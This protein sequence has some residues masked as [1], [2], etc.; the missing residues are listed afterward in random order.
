MKRAILFIIL[1]VALIIAFSSPLRAQSSNNRNQKD[2]LRQEILLAD[3]DSKLRLYNGLASL[4]MSEVSRDEHIIDTI[5]ALYDEM[6]A[7]A[8]KSGNLTYQGYARLNKL[9]ALSNKGA[10]DEIIQGVPAALDFLKEHSQWNSYYQALALLCDTYG[11]KGETET[12]LREAQLLYEDA[13]ARKHIGGT[14]VALRSISKIYKGKRRF[15][16]AEKCLRECIELL[17]DSISYYSVLLD[18][19]SDLISNLIAQKRYEDA[20]QM[21]SEYEKINLYYEKESKSS[22]PGVWSNLWNQYIYIYLQSGD[23]DRAEIYINKLDSISN[24]SR[25]LSEERAQV[26]YGKKQYDEA[27]EIIN[28]KI[29]LSPNSLQSKGL[30]LMILIQMGKADEGY[31]LFRNVIS[32]LDSLRNTEFNAR[33]DEIHTQYQVDKH[34]AEKE[35]N[36]N[37]FFFALGGCCVFIALLA[38]AFYYNRIITKKN[39][40]L[41]KQINEQRRIYEDV[42]QM[43]LQI[44]VE[45]LSRELKLYLKLQRLMQTE[46][47]F[48]DPDFDRGKLIERLGTN[49]QYLAD[50]LKQ[51]AGLTFGAY[52]TDLRLKYALEL[53]SDHPNLTLDAIALDSGHGSYSSFFR[54]FTQK[55]GMSPSEFRKF[56][57]DKM[58]DTLQVNEKEEV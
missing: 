29:E 47:L 22:Q 11:R 25:N 51:E 41:Y 10:Y 20:L 5:F 21:A 37:Y 34:I 58:I 56:S 17:P 12:A 7:E 6:N 30:K 40:S 31:S 43:E 27:L 39:H 23:Y 28:K 18:T 49:R 48:A 2:S 36:R 13:K 33:V 32:E 4:Y 54:A 26:F 1:S 38:G 46:K 53:L 42:K 55:Y 45:N 3:G 9:I 19:Y 52:L 50:A 24:G 15:E 16:E 44:P 35:R 8:E 57:S 14:A